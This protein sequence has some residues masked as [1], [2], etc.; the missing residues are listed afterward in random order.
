MNKGELMSTTRRLE[1]VFKACLAILLGVSWSLL[2]AES[3]AAAKGCDPN[4]PYQTSYTPYC[5]LI[6]PDESRELSGI[7]F[8]YKVASCSSPFGNGTDGPGYFYFSPVSGKSGELTL[9]RTY[10]LEVFFGH[11]CRDFAGAYDLDVKLVASSGRTINATLVKESYSSYQSK[12]YSTVNNYC[13]MY[14]CGTT[15]FYYTI[16]VPKSAESGTY[17]VEASVKSD[18][19][20]SKYSY[21]DVVNTFHFGSVFF[22]GSPQSSVPTP[23]PSQSPAST[24]SPAPTAS[25]PL[26]TPAPVTGTPEANPSES[27]EPKSEFLFQEALTK[28]K[29]TSKTLSSTQK[30]EI[31]T[32]LRTLKSKSKILCIGTFVKLSDSSLALSRAKAVCSYAKSID[33]ANSYFAKVKSTKVVSFDDRV[34]ISSK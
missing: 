19:T 13:L 12:R 9:G 27:S 23:S 15:Y 2:P 18:A 25:P 6:Y 32:L 26:Q 22:I 31:R 8:Q 4:S 5:Y 1:L 29:G 24:S 3:F 30:S 20:K 17:S 34:I 16:T 10:N 14:S 33:S 28:F 7:K 11:D 21:P